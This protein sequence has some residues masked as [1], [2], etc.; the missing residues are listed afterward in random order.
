MNILWLDLNSSY[1]HSS[2]ALPCIHAQ[3]NENK[4]NWAV[5]RTTINVNNATI[6]RDIVS[7]NPDI[8][9]ATAWIFTAENFYSILSRLNKFFLNVIFLV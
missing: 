3:I 2:L 1:S 5:L 8:I 7:A 4:N 9:L 6:V